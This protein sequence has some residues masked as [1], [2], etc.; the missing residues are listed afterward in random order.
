M[1]LTYELGKKKKSQTPDG[2]RSAKNKWRENMWQEREECFTADII[3]WLEKAKYSKSPL[4]TKEFQHHRVAQTLA[5]DDLG[6]NVLC[7]QQQSY[8]SW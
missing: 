4:S 7:D 1:R 6:W 3:W 2:L 8:D 5:Q